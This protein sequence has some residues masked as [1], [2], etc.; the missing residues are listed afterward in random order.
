MYIYRSISTYSNSLNKN[1]QIKSLFLVLFLSCD[2]F[3]NGRFI[4]NIYRQ[5]HIYIYR[6]RYTCFTCSL[7][8]SGSAFR[9]FTILLQA[10]NM[11]KYKVFYNQ[12]RERRKGTKDTH[13]HNRKCVSKST[14]VSINFYSP[15]LTVPRFCHLKT[16][17][18][19]LFQ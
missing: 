4:H 10:V 8:S 18:M 1:K 13:T 16:N 9:N 2:C 7:S 5:I 15:I 14:S 19:R 12:Q 17:M 11:L 6:Y 3:Q